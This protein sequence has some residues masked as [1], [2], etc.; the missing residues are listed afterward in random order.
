MQQKINFHATAMPSR[1][2]YNKQ[3]A[4][5]DVFLTGRIF[6]REGDYWI[7]DPRQIFDN[8]NDPA[9]DV[10]GANVD[11][12]DISFVFGDE[13]PNADNVEGGDLYSAENL[14]PQF[15]RA[16]VDDRVWVPIPAENSNKYL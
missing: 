4:F 15:W 9:N 11:G 14:A 1:A 12:T 5:G 16:H 2:L 7:L 10:A 6:Y 13:L 8:D 3:G